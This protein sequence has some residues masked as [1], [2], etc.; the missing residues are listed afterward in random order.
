MHLLV[1]HTN[2]NT[3]NS[4]EIPSWKCPCILLCS[5]FLLSLSPHSLTPTTSLLL[6]LVEALTGLQT[7]SKNNGRGSNIVTVKAH[8]PQ[9]AGVLPDFDDQID[10]AFIVILNPLYAIPSFFNH[11]HEMKNHVRAPI[12][13]WI[14]WRDMFVQNQISEFKLFIM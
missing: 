13:A 6:L 8:Y 12:E 2:T 3:R 1:L 11:I 9:S 5:F 10:R 4:N 14:E 7:C